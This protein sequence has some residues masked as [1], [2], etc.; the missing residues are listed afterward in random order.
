LQY[1]GGRDGAH[2]VVIEGYNGAGK[3]SLLEAITFCLFG[4]AGLALVARASGQAKPEQSYDRFLERALNISA[5]GEAARMSVTLEFEMGAELAGIERAWHFNATGRHR[6]DDEEVRLFEGADF[7]LVLTPPPPDG[8]EFIRS[9]VAQR[10]IPPNLAG[11]FLLDGEHLERLSSH[12][13]DDQ[14]WQAIEAVLGAPM[15]RSLAVDLRD[16]GR[17]RRRAMP[18]GIDE[19]TSAASEA[20]HALSMKE[21]EVAAL[22]DELLGQLMPLRRQ[23]E[24][25]VRRIGSLRG[26]SYK[27]FKTLFEHREASSRHRDEQRDELRRLLGGDVAFALAGPQLRAR[28]VERLALE[29][30]TE[31]WQSGSVASRNRFAEFWSNLQ[32]HIEEP[33]PEQALRAAWDELWNKAPDGCVSEIRHGHLGEAERRS[34]V[35]HLNRLAAVSADII[36]DLSRGIAVFDKQIL[37]VE[38]EIG[39][40]RGMDAESQALADELTQIQQKIA[41]IEADHA[42]H[43]ERLDALR[44]ELALKRSALGDLLADTANAVPL[45]ERATLAERFAELVDRLIEAAIPANL[46]DISDAVSRAYREMAHKS[47]VER[48]QILPGEKVLLLDDEGA[49]VGRVDASAGESQIFALAVMSGLAG[50]AAEFPIVMDT[51]LA[52]LD[53]VHRRNVLTHFARGSRQLILLTHP[54]EL[55]SEELAMLAPYLAGTVEIGHRPDGKVANG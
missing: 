29:D 49:D 54:A 42:M 18:Q 14:L 41:V 40:Q 6:T 52:R 11:F 9:F 32:Q 23:R 43:I 53:P 50:L 45:L 5:Q 16:Y 12:S 44:T 34:V 25:I 2:V 39:R 38:S 35:D 48:I 1:R 31:R 36:A 37:E 22:A 21:H 28:A 4:R 46:T 51:P 19:R 17:E 24:G 30:R 47:V 10:F 15:L 20:L 3:T 55:G 7:D 33:V 26:D 13:V 8:E 27:T